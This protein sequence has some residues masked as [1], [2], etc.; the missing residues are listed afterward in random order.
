MTDKSLLAINW[1]FQKTISWGSSQWKLKEEDLKEVAE[2][3]NEDSPEETGK[4]IWT[5][6]RKKFSENFYI[7]YSYERMGTDFLKY[8]NSY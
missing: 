7:T 1:A 3:I 4:F 2:G 8:L 5:W 6:F